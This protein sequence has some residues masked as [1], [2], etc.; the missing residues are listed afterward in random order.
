MRAL[1]KV[2]ATVAEW[3]VLVVDDNAAN[4]ELARRVLTRAGLDRVIEVQDPARVRDVLEADEPDLVL[5][6][7]RMPK[8]DGFEVLEI[9]QRHAAGSFLPVIVVTADDSR[10]SV[11]RALTMGAHDF[12]TKPFNASELVLRVRNLLLMR[13]AYV[14]LR[15]N[16]AWLRSRLHLFEP[17]LAL[18]LGDNAQVR[19]AIEQA[20][21]EHT[22]DLAVQPV[23]DMR[24]GT[25]IGGEALARFHSDLL[26]NTGAWFAAAMEHD[27]TTALERVTFR[28]ALELLPTRPPGTTLSINVSPTTVMAG[29]A[30]LCGDDVPWEQVVLEL[31]EH[32]PVEDY[33]A[34]NRVLDPLR[35][36]GARLAIDDTGAGF[37]SLRHILD[38][39]PDIIKIDT[40]I[41]RGIDQ[42]PSRA[43]IGGMLVHFADTLG[44][45][46]I[47][48]GVETDAER[49]TLLGLGAVYGQGFLLGRPVIVT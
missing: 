3:T 23:V 34:L 44:I 22:F 7:L 14:E 38:L 11:E 29:L 12:L 21:R 43:A 46:L 37:A 18:G 19:R 16:R 6:D 35:A 45:R 15:R 9:I 39:H 47:A 48:E 1:D 49:A 25:V 27:L 30:E 8:M 17:D 41:T 10:T 5:L 28:R 31:T 20:I 24:D 26:P 33:A 42:D 4:T 2:L 40:G 32:V 13:E 36:A